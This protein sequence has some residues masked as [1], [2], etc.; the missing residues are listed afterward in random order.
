MRKDV[1]KGKNQLVEENTQ[2]YIKKLVAD[3]FH[4]DL[5]VY[6]QVTR[7]RDV[8]V[9]KQICIYFLRKYLKDKT[10][11]EIGRHFRYKCHASTLHG[12]RQVEACMAYDKKFR[13]NVETLDLQI[14]NYV[15]R[16]NSEVDNE[17]MVQMTDVC[18]LK[19]NARKK[20]MLSGF[21]DDEINEFSKNLNPILKKKF[22][23]TGIFLINDK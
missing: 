17:S 22:N 9:P 18:L 19:L 10:L 23:N 5:D 20:I 16:I 11:A 7:L 6:K 8:V 12:A 2:N 14:R 13:A 1:I 21:T 15:H 3:Y 4:H